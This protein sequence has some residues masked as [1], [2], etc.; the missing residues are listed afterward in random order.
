MV[1]T[2]AKTDATGLGREEAME[3]LGTFYLIK[4]CGLNFRQLAVANG[5]A[6]SK[7]FK[8]EDN[9]ARYT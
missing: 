6:F 5:T 3:P 8:K 2:N 4:T 1:K 7:I 9:L